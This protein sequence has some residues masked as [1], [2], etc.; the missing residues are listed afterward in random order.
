M[1]WSEHHNQEAIDYAKRWFNYHTDDEFG[2]VQE[3]IES[4]RNTLAMEGFIFDLSREVLLTNL[5]KHGYAL[6]T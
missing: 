2:S 3:V 5:I 6:Y 4:A 1:S